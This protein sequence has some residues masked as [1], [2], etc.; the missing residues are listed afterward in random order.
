M[1]PTTA[2]KLA[3]SVF[4]LGLSLGFVLR[5][6]IVRWA[7]RRIGELDVAPEWL[8]ELCMS[9]P[10]HFLD[11][12]SD[13]NRIG[14]GVDPV[15]TCGA[16]FALLPE[17]DDY[18]FDQTAAFAKRIYKITYQCLK[19]DWSKPLLKTTDGLADDFEFL[20][21]GYLA[22][23]EQS[24]IGAVKEFVRHH[25]SDEIIGLLDPVKW[26]G[27]KDEST[28]QVPA[29]PGAE[30]HIGL[31]SWI[32]QDGNY[33]DF[34]VGQETKFALEF[35][36][37]NGLQPCADIALAAE[38]IRASRYRIRGRIV[39]SEPNVWVI[40]VGTFKAFS[41]SK[42]PPHAV[43]GILVEGDICL[44]IDP[45]F[46]FEYLHRMEGMPPLTYT[47]LVRSILRETTPLINATDAQGRGFW[48][49]D[50]SRE[51]FLPAHETKAWDDDGGNAE[52]VL[53]CERLRGP[54][55][56]AS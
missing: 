18:T 24:V 31:S 28:E 4:A 11:L 53:K 13:L 46:Y 2:D 42:P 9:K 8:I 43:V 10:K 20:R 35:Y 40:D 21:E 19:G 38:H 36:P 6:D 55:M 15:A 34:S 48:K 45:F 22:A 17:V 50:E 3:A 14:E 12:I 32:I 39:F 27:G 26:V 56:P 47:W 16:T 49:R 29:A 33:G 25:R 52:Y 44:G 37:P 7:D 5:E 54:E 51:G 23:T 30:V 1:I 41:E